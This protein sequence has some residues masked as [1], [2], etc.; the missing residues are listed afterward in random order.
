MR[1]FNTLTGSVERFRPR[2]GQTVAVYVCGITP[3]DT[4]H[5]GHAFTYV[6][7]DVLM[8]H[9]ETVHA[10]PVRYVQNL[11]DID[12]DVLKRAAEVGTDWRSLGEEWTTRF[13][14][15]MQALNV[16]PP[17]AFPG[18]TAYIP[19]IQEHVAA[20]IDA[21]AAYERN[22]NVYFRV[23]G[24]EGFG[25]LS[26]LEPEQMLATANERG[27]VPDDPDKDDPL[28]FVLWQAGK[29]GEPAWRSPWGL[30]RPGWHIECSTMA[31]QLLRGTVDIHG[32][33]RDLLFPHHACEIAQCDAI[34]DG[35][36]FTRFW[37]H[38][39]MVRMDGEKMSK[40][41]GNLVLVRDLLDSWHPDTIR[42]YLLRSHYRQAW[43][44]DPDALAATDAW[45]R[46]LHAAIATH[47]GPADAPALDPATYGP[48]F[49]SA[50]DDDLDT[51]T[52]VEVVLHLADDILA[53]SAK[54]NVSAAQDVL[55]A[56]AGH[57][58]GLWLRPVAEIPAEELA[59]VAWPEPETA[60]PDVAALGVSEAS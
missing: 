30:G 22:G 33:G 59:A 20:L 34:G 4:T 50:L 56:L 53:A 16:R 57:I 35:G 26:G 15:D 49:T 9:L 32:G 13:V 25:A 54:T 43:E 38:V 40:S 11:T 1:L 18:A 21:G 46:T 42:L 29:P 5:L 36:A 7:F 24:D 3:Y 19:Q 27:N 55:R 6:V 47:A 31:T 10:W 8:R 51:P 58:L 28:D 45:V 14:R 17:D 41:L 60:P 12:D 44:W 39:A 52:A 48:R 2:P 37:A 23:S